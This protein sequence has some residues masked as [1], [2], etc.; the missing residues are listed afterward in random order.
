MKRGG[1]PVRAGDLVPLAE[2]ILVVR[3]EL[4]QRRKVYPRLVTRGKMTKEYAA[5][6]IW[7]MQAV[8]DTLNAA[9]GMPTA[10]QPNLEI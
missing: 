1:A 7:G 3:R 2:Q 8:L 10:V 4:A 6:E 5:R 9:A